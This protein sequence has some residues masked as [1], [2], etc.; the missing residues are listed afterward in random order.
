MTVSEFESHIA[1]DISRDVQSIVQELMRCNDPWPLRVTVQNVAMRDL[2]LWNASDKSINLLYAMTRVEKLPNPVPFGV[3]VLSQVSFQG[4]SL[5]D[6]LEQLNHL[7]QTQRNCNRVAFLCKYLGLLDERNPPY[8]AR[9]YVDG[10]LMYPEKPTFTYKICVPC[11]VELMDNDGTYIR[12]EDMMQT[13]DEAQFLELIQDAM[14]HM[15]GTGKSAVPSHD[16]TVNDAVLAL[17][18]WCGY[19]MSTS[20]KHWLMHFMVNAQMRTDTNSDSWLKQFLKN[21]LKEDIKGQ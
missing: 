2:K 8:F 12:P 17:N 20:T 11:T 10:Q 6:L 5:D 16:L 18:W 9:L 21:L 15:S 7:L 1:F 13:K 14:H 19:V 3:Q 4:L